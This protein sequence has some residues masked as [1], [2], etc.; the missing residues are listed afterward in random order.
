MFF[1]V[2][3]AHKTHVFSS[4][5]IDHLLHCEE[6]MLYCFLLVCNTNRDIGMSQL[7]IISYTYLSGVRRARIT[8]SEGRSDAWAL[9]DFRGSGDKGSAFTLVSFSTFG[10]IAT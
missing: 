4:Q 2:L 6:S 8:A 3:E 9:D 1:Q 10:W 5:I 7:G